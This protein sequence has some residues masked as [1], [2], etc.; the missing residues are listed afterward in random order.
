MLRSKLLGLL[1]FPLL[2]MAQ[3]DYFFRTVNVK[4][5]LADNFVRD[6][7]RD[8]HGYIWLSTINGL[9]RYDGYRLRNYQ[10]TDF[11]ARSNDVTAVRETADSTLWMLCI[12]D[13]YTFRRTDDVWKK[14]GTSRLTA[15]GI[16]GD[17]HALCVDDR[18]NLWVATDQGLYYYE[19]SHRK[20]Q[21]YRYDGTPIVHITSR[22]ETTLVVT[23]DYHIYKVSSGNRLVSVTHAPAN[24]HY[25]RDS[26][27]MLDSRSNLWLYHAHDLAGTQWVYTL[28]DRKWQQAKDLKAI[29]NTTVNAIAEDASGRL[30]V[31]TGN[32][33][34]T[35]FSRDDSG[36]GLNPVTTTSI[37][38]PHSSHVTCLYLDADNSMWIG[39][40]KLGAAFTDLGIPRFN[41]Q[42]IATHEDVSSLLA[43]GQGNLWIAFDGGGIVRHSPEGDD[44]HF[45]AARKQLPSDIVTSLTRT[46]DGSI[47]AGT[48]GQG[49]ARL[50]G[51]TFTPLH[52]SYDDL[53]YVKAMTTDRNG[54]LWVATVDRGVV[55]VTPGG[56]LVS[57]T[58]E[59]S[60][61]ASNGTLCLACDS[62]RN[63]V[64]IGTSVG[65]SIFDCQKDWFVSTPGTDSLKGAY[66]T[67]LLVADRVWIGTRN[68][69]WAY[70]P[71]DD[72]AMSFTTAQGMSHNV[73]RAIACSGERLWVSTDN[74][75]TLLY[76]SSGKKGTKSSGKR[77][78]EEIRCRPFLASDGLH[79]IVFSNNAALSTVDGQVL[80]G[81]Y[82]GY[83]SIPPGCIA[84]PKPKLHIEFTEFRI[85]GQP[86]V[87]PTTGFSI[88]HDQRLGISVSMMVPALCHKAAYYYRFKGEKE[89]M[90]APANMLFFATLASGTHV[91]QVK[92]EL[93]GTTSTAPSELPIKVLPPWWMSNAAIACYLLL[94]I[95][96]CWLIYRILRQRQQRELAIKQLEVNLKQYELE[97]EKINFFTN[98]SHDIKT[99]LTMVLGP[100]EKIRNDKL[101]DIVRTE[102]DVAWHNAKQLSDLVL[103]LLDFRRLDVG[104]EKLSLSHGDLIGF[105]RQTVQDFA[106]YAHRKQLKLQLALPVGAFETLF[107]ESKLRRIIINLLSN[108][109]KYNVEGGTITVSLDVSNA[110][111]QGKI[112]LSVADTGIGIHNKRHIF[113]RF[114]Q[115]HH[116]GTPHTLDVPHDQEGSGLGLYIVRQYVDMIGGR[117]DVTD[118]EPQGTIFT[119]TLPVTSSPPQEETEEL[120]VEEPNTTVEKDTQRDRPTILIVED[121]ID[122]QQFLQ[123]NIEDEFHV[124]TANDGREALRLLAKNE[125]IALIISD[126]IMPGMDGIQLVRKIKHNIRFS[127]IP[128]ILLTAKSSEEDIIAGLSEGV[129]DYIAKPFNMNVLRLR[130]H[131][132]LEWTQQVHQK[133]ATG[134][135]IEPTEMTVSSID[136]ELVSHVIADIEAHIHDINYSVVQLSSAVG[137]TRGNLYKKLIAI[138]G[139]SPVEFIRIVR[140]KRGKS[141]IDQGRT[142]ISEVADA[143]G[144]SPKLFAHY[145]KLMYGETP[146]EY[147]KSNRTK[148]KPNDNK[149]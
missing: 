147:L 109:C 85:N 49:L 128:I 8:S 133:V 81:H 117:I 141:L 19:Y 31:G 79:D 108:A 75:L 139:K 91:L 119:V 129:A 53:R 145:F 57:Y 3:S 63:K 42:T 87:K 54:N 142:N 94:F 66:V 65:L 110:N 21:H 4:D 13:L 101:P 15:M 138:A 7:V 34:I 74:G 58:S 37:F 27:V 40:A 55:R 29:G 70:S 67:S 92:A 146:S 96:L 84:T 60:P 88:Q 103:Q 69:L 116:R 95:L 86:V 61:L 23:E 99:P 82:T 130:I 107:D 48:Y 52:P 111:S 32:S 59:N 113:D 149:L 50:H 36:T 125:D 1:L 114:M 102:L 44:I 33:G 140:L 89:W 131:K 43:D 104:K 72:N 46:A 22:A 51:S 26:R 20:L 71:A 73:V 100:L 118:N 115:E 18:G 5:G 93:P 77:S 24:F 121:N 10:P 78:L 135:N 14:D 120:P 41:I 12:G 148:D 112:V 38:K 11:G 16:E 39:S 98:I 136:Q 123:R 68:G 80:L 45:S 137:M 126:V 30:W 124:V 47:I 90:R 28:A 106:Y 35:I 76:Y 132:I 122:A 143:V 83:V 134:I 97:E 105:V 127:H 2:V 17:I 144:I 64:Y 56:R 25:S 62:L 9:S 6:I